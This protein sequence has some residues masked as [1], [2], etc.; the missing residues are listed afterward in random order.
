MNSLSP[1]FKNLLMTK[2]QIIQS[3]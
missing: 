1:K 2:S 3:I